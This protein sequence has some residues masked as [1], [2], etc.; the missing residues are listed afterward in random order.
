MEDACWTLPL[1]QCIYSSAPG[2]WDASAGVLMRSA[3]GATGSSRQFEP[4]SSKNG[5]NVRQGRTFHAVRRSQGHYTP[6]HPGA[7]SGGVP[8]KGSV[9]ERLRGSGGCQ[10]DE[11]LC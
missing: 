7:G 5:R 6:A 3:H 11:T 10:K 8:D 1:F 2:G 4:G 9:G